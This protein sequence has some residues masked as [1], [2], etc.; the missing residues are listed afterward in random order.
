MTGVGMTFFFLDREETCQGKK[1]TNQKG[2]HK[3]T[4]TPARGNTR[5]SMSRTHLLKN[6]S[7]GNTRRCQSL[8]TTTQSLETTT[9]SPG[10]TKQAVGTTQQSLLARKLRLVASKQSLGITELSPVVTPQTPGTTTQAPGA[11]EQ[12]LGGTEQPNAMQ[13]L[14]SRWQPLFPLRSALSQPLQKSGP[15]LRPS[16]RT[17]CSSSSSI[18]RSS[19]PP[20]ATQPGTLG[21]PCRAAPSPR[22]SPLHSAFRDRR[23]QPRRLHP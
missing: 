23:Q 14:A 1:K 16:P 10:T 8:G 17:C 2:I 20:A 7:G 12:L 3:K 13:V 6:P 21:A 15:P 19:R 9:Q 5:T 11:A 18:P 4:K 22:P